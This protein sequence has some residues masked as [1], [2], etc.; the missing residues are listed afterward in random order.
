MAPRIRVTGG[1]RIF[2]DALEKRA[3]Y[4]QVGDD[5][6]LSDRVHTGYK[7]SLDGIFDLQS[8]QS[9]TLPM[10]DIAAV[11]GLEIRGNGD[12][13][14]AINGAA[15]ITCS[16]DIASTDVTEDLL[17]LLRGQISSVVISLPASPAGVTATGTW[18]LWGDPS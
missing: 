11:R 8:G 14:V 7:K 2:T 13:Q 9:I 4:D 6:T 1:A 15:A 3:V 17:L 18:A 12:I 5:A 16:R 10:T